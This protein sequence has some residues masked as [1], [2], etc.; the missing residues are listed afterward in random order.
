MKQDWELMHDG[1]YYVRVANG[2]TARVFLASTNPDLYS[3]TVWVSSRRDPSTPPKVDERRISMD[4][5]FFPNEEEAKRSARRALAVCMLM[6][7]PGVASVLWAPIMRAAEAT[8][9][10]VK[11]ARLDGSDEGKPPS[12]YRV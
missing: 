9:G 12:R 8:R 7:K 11:R 6:L 3:F 1:S 4:G 5:E 2:A 10:L